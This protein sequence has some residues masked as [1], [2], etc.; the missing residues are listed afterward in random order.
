LDSKVFNC[1]ILVQQMHNTCF[2]N[3]R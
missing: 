2:L 1:I 3:K